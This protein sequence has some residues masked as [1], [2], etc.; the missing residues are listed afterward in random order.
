MEQIL[1]DLYIEPDLLNELSEDQKQILFCKI[2]EEQVHRWNVRECTEPAPARRARSGRRGIQWLLGSNGEVWVWVMGEATGDKSYAEISEQLMEER[3]VKQAQQEALELRRVKEAEIEKKFRE[4]VAKE[5][6]HFAAEKWRVDMDDRKAAKQEEEEERIR[7][8]LKKREEE[9]RQ[10]GEEEIRQTE[11]RR[12]KELYMSLKQE[13]KGRERD[14]REWQEQCERAEG[15]GEVRAGWGRP[16]KDEPFPFKLL[17]PAVRRSKA[18]DEEMTRKARCA[19]DEY[20]R[21]S[22]RAVQKGSGQSGRR[23][24][25]HEQPP[26]PGEASQSPVAEGSSVSS[27]TVHYCRRHNYRCS[28]PATQSESSVCARPASRDSI[29][30]WFKEEQMPRRACYERNSNAIAPW[31]HDDKINEHLTDN[32]PLWQEETDDGVTASPLCSIKHAQL[33]HYHTHSL[34]PLCPLLIYNLPRAACLPPG[35]VVLFR[36]LFHACSIAHPSLSPRAPP[37]IISRQ[38]AEALLINASEGCFLVR[39]SEWIWG[40]TLSYRSA[41]GFKHFLIDASGDYYGFL[42]ADQN[43]HATLADLIDFHK[44]RPHRRPTPRSFFLHPTRSFLQAGKQPWRLRAHAL[45]L[46][47]ACAPGQFRESRCAC[48]QRH[49]GR[50][51]SW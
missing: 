1:R 7:K 3:A 22:L 11:E 16:F 36:C 5:K 24:S 47:L 26:A 37:G 38:E 15:V 50:Q 4:A 45:A 27:A 18:A 20:K 9:E 32:I 17:C 6:A 13:E 46:E 31:F 44:V 2:R 40:Y 12:A 51:G 35:R 10:R 39:V 8:A 29:M 33:I 49:L 21:Q 43:R 41:S 25:V 48:P 23:S 30:R 42:G 28:G 14:D 19:R 34:C